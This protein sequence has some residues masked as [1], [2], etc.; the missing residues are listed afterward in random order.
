MMALKSKVRVMYLG[1]STDLYK[2]LY[3][4]PM[5]FGQHEIYYD[6]FDSHYDFA[7]HLPG[8][9]FKYLYDHST[10]TKV[11]VFTIEKVRL[12]CSRHCQ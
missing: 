6:L 11:P 1:S 5:A 10:N 2:D 3:G 4:V 9:T 7:Q 8:S 12:E